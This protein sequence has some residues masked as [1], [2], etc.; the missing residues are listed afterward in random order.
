MGMGEVD[1][2]LL[3]GADADG[4]G[5]E[6]ERELAFCGGGLGLAGCGECWGDEGCERGG[7]EL[8]AEGSTGHG[9]DDAWFLG[10]GQCGLGSGYF[11]FP[12][13]WVAEGV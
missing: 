4:A 13:Q 2:F 8:A 1:G 9:L 12:L 10:K 11:G 7:A 6:A 3:V 5:V